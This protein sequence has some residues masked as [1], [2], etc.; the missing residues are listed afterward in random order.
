MATYAHRFVVRAPLAA[1]A[2]FHADSHA[3]RRL[4]PPPVFVQFHQVGPLSEGSVAEFTLWLG[5]LPI[6]WVA[7]HTHFDPLRGFTDNMVRG[8]LA[9]CVHRHDFVPL[10]P[11]LT[12]V[13]DHMDYAYLPGLRGLRGRLLMSPFSLPILFAFRSF[14][15]RRTVERAHQRRLR[16][17]PA[18]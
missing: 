13:E 1:V 10:G 11:E 17:A 5:P 16:S 12:A 6:Y 18:A 14:V 7:R 4:T 9:H 2:T 15:T 8:P 3:L